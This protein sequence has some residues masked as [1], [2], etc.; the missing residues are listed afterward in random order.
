MEIREV[1]VIAADTASHAGATAHLAAA[2]TP[3]AALARATAHR[4]VVVAVMQVAADI[5]AVVV[6]TP[7]A[8]VVDKF[9]ARV[10]GLPPSA[11]TGRLL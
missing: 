8:V 10:R 7:E 1:M 9:N 6:A 2:I 4:V 11:G 3:V 5:P